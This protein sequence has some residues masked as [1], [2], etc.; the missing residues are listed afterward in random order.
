MQKI[1]D[2]LQEAEWMFFDDENGEANII[3]ENNVKI[4]QKLI[5][6]FGQKIKDKI[7]AVWRE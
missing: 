6:F 4:T 7:T 2:L 3:L 1:N 5:E